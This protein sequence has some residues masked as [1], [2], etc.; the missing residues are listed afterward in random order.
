MT[1]EKKLAGPVFI[2]LILA[3]ALA[4]CLGFWETNLA[5]ADNERVIAERRAKIQVMAL[6][7]LVELEVKSHKY[8]RDPGI[9]GIVEAMLNDH[10]GRT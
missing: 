6:A 10:L 3:T 8:E 4:A 1:S 7:E 2:G 9:K 5:G